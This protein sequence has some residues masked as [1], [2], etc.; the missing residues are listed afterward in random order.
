MIKSNMDQPPLQAHTTISLMWQSKW[1]FGSKK[2]N[3]V[4]L[5]AGLFLLLAC[6]SVFL[7]TKRVVQASDNARPSGQ[8]RLDLRA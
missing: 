5:W 6:S 1:I 2:K 3:K 7:V 8:S 4:G